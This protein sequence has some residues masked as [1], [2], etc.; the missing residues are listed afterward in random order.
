MIDAIIGDAAGS[1][2][3]SDDCMSKDFD[4][5]D[6]RCDFSDDSVMTRSCTNGAQVF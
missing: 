3:E 5:L 1:R 4:M 6:R 2:F